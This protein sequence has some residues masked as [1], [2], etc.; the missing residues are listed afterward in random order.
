MSSRL[1]AT[2]LAALVGAVASLG[3]GC[4]SD[5]AAAVELRSFVAPTRL[6]DGSVR[7]RAATARTTIH[8]GISIRGRRVVAYLC[9]GDPARRRVQRIG[10]WFMGRVGRNGS[11]VLTSRKGATLSAWRRGERLTGT[12]WLRDG[13]VLSF[14]A[15]RAAGTARF[16]YVPAPDPAATPLL[17]WIRLSNGAE[18][19]TFTQALVSGNVCRTTYQRLKLLEGKQTTTGLTT[20]EREELML[21]RAKYARDCAPSAATS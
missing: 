12:V 9:D 3:M 7:S 20:A 17:G 14:S 15:R 6:G 19:G 13:R 11:I 16:L 21:L 1:L 4:A 8:I 10:E 5:A 18:R 2:A